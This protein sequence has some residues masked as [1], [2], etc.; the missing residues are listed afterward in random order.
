LQPTAPSA[1]SQRVNL[2]SRPRPVEPGGVGSNPLFQAAEAVLRAASAASPISGSGPGVSIASG[3][4]PRA[5]HSGSSRRRAA[6]HGGYY[7]HPRTAFRDSGH[8]LLTGCK[9][10]CIPDCVSMLLHEYYSTV[11]P[12]GSFDPVYVGNRDPTFERVGRVLLPYGFDL[13]RVTSSFMLPGGIEMAVLASAGLYLLHLALNYADDRMGPDAN[14]QFHCYAYDGRYLRDN[15]RYTRP[16]EVVPSDYADR[17]S[18]RAVFN[19]LFDKDTTVRLTNV[20]AL[21]QV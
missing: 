9:K 5:S 8:T 12:I 13:Q 20:Y 11:L 21:R 14:R 1:A 16:V 3:G 19:A 2:P 7:F 17:F 4:E 10:S 18:A 15:D 6:T